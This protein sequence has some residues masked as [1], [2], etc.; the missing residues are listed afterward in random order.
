M[1]ER[2]QQLKI[3]FE[4]LETV[5]EIFNGLHPTIIWFSDTESKYE[6]SFVNFEEKVIWL[7]GAWY[8]FQEQQ[9]RIDSL[10]KH[11]NKFMEL[12]VDDMGEILK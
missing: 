5:S 11:L 7:N 10:S 2:I 3:D 12:A 8:A 1:K 9:K 4:K 6:T